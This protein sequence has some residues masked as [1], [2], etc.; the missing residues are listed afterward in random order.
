MM[1]IEAEFGSIFNA[2]EEYQLEE[3]RA[4]SKWYP[5]LD[6]VSRK[7]KK[8]DFTRVIEDANKRKE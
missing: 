8:N 4:K 5:F 6:L 2:S 1:A 3:A 7:K